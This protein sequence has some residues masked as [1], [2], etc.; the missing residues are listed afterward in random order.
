MVARHEALR[1]TFDVV[2]GQPVQRIAPWSGLTLPWIDLRGLPE[3]SRAAESR[4]LAA[5]EGQ[6]PFDLAAGPLL[7]VALL[8]MDEEEHVVV[9]CM[10]HI[11]SDGW[12]VGVLIREVGT[13]YEA[14]VAGLPSPLPSLPVQYVDFAAWQRSWLT[15]EVLA[16]Q[17]AYWRERLAGAPPVLELPSDRPRPVTPS[18]RG[19]TRS[20]VFSGPL[21][22]SLGEYSRRAGTTLFMTL[23]AG[24]DALLHLYTGQEDLVVGTDVAGRGRAETEV[25]IGF[26]INQLVLRVEVAGD[27]SFAELLARVRETALGAYAHQ[28]VPF[29]RVVEELHPER[30]LT[31]MPLFQAMFV[32]QNTPLGKLELPGLT[33]TPVPLGEGTAKY[34]LTVS[35]MEQPDGL[36]ATAEY[37][38]DL[39]DNPTIERLF[40]HFGT[41]LER[42]LVPRRRVCRRC[43]CWASRS[44]TSCW[45]SGTTASRRSRRRG[46]PRPSWWRRRRRSVRRRWRSCGA[47]RHGA[48]VSWSSEP[49]EWPGS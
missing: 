21:G 27:P 9:L 48:T 44:V 46:S 38:T 37:S 1:T 30:T 42:V 4:R 19:Q 26:F 23:L 24:F 16:A 3:P 17:L 47:R 43:R 39:F 2:E 11:V 32:L 40:G 35:V 7:R 22:R 10:H 34:D 25:L 33:L 6:R 5:A 49:R 29:D 12:S 36:V 45:W 8:V 41:L 20:R 31:R 14:G 18:G 13:L 15:G 28:D